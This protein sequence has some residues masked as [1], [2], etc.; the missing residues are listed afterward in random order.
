M[1]ILRP[2]L[3]SSGS[4]LQTNGRGVMNYLFS[5]PEPLAQTIAGLI[6][7]EATEIIHSARG[8]LVR[9]TSTLPSSHVLTPVK[10][11]EDHLQHEIQYDAALKATEKKAL[12]SARIGQGIFK[13]NVQAFESHCRLT[14]VQNPNHLIGS[15]IKPW[16]HSN[17]RER[18][19][20]ENG[21]LLTPSIDHLFDK[22]YIS[23][24]GTGALLISPIADRESLAK[25]GVRDES[26]AIITSFTH[27]QQ[28]YLEF[29]RDSIFLC[30]GR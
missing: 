3:P 14:G 16:R 11:W 6:G 7:R 9:S 15:H 4:P 17:N 27:I 22:G 23:F 24:R 12:V 13:S 21:L 18:L 5:I 26:S 20:G 29:H 19:D 2:L 28:Q 25:M 8:E 1:D 30:R 10:E